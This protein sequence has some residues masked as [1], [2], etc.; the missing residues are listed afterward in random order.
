M[1]THTELLKASL[2]LFLPNSKVTTLEEF[3]ESWGK[4]L[5][6]GRRRLFADKRLRLEN[7]ERQ[8]EDEIESRTAQL[9]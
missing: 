1:K 3:T 2:S 5:S 4:L 8:T 6:R 9:Q 7:R